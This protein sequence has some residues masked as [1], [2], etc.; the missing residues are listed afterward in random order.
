M[1]KPIKYSAVLLLS[2]CSS[3]MTGCMKEDLDNMRKEFQELE[4]QVNSDAV[5]LTF[6]D[7]DEITGEDNT[8]TL[9]NEIFSQTGVTVQ[10]RVESKSADGTDILTKGQTDRWNISSSVSGNT[11]EIAVEP[12]ENV[13]LNEKAILKVEVTSEDGEQLAYGQKVFTNGIFTGRMYVTSYSD[14]MA[15]IKKA[16]KSKPVDIK[17]IGTLP[18]DEVKVASYY[19]FIEFF[20]FAEIGTLEVSIP[21]LTMIWPY[22]FD[23]SSNFK[24]F[25]SDY[26]TV[27]GDGLTGGMFWKS[28]VEEVDLPNLTLLTQMEFSNCK[29]LRSVNFPNVKEVNGSQ[30]FFECISLERLDLPN[31]TTFTQLNLGNFARSCYNLKEVNMPKVTTLPGSAF[32][33]CYSLVQIDLPEVTELGQ[34]VFWNCK[35]LSKVSLPKLKELPQRTFAGCIAFDFDANIDTE[36][37]EVTKVGHSAFANCTG[38]TSAILKSVTSIGASAFQGCTSLGAMKLGAVS[39]VDSTAFDGMDTES[40]TLTFYGTPTAGELDRNNKTWCGKKWKAINII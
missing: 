16:D 29:K 37:G 26:V 14:F 5:T 33:D 34:D 12:S 17:V 7:M 25:K 40:C 19:P 9:E 1:K 15:Q 28:S 30:V 38:M 10:V 20:K 18:A 3:V 21:E 2:V 35:S 11:L 24:V 8:F 13:F 6:N 31:L 39:E 4:E 36:L 22:T 27:L 32:M 23:G